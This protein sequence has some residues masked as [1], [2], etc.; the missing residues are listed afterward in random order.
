MSL[1]PEARTV[2][3]DDGTDLAYDSLIVATG[4]KHSYFGNDQWSEHAPGIKTLED[5]LQMRARILDA[6]ENAEL[7][8]DSAKQHDW[9][10]FVIVGGGPTGV[11]YAGAL[12]ELVHGPILKDYP[13]IP[14]DEIHI[15][16]ADRALTAVA[17]P[18]GIVQAE[19]ATAGGAG[20]EEGGF[21]RME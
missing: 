17:Y 10:T 9:M 19:Y 14:P 2:R 7:E 15:L 11:E 5:A 3:I 4:T 6:F 8:T 1:D 20:R 21:R 12:A 16:A 18:G 13:N